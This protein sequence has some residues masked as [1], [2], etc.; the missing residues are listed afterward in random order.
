[1]SPTPTSFKSFARAF[2]TFCVHRVAASHVA[3]YHAA[4]RKHRPL[5]FLLAVC[6]CLSG[7]RK[8]ASSEPP[9]A[10]E[11]GIS[12]YF[13]PK[14]GCTAAIVEQL[15]AAMQTIDMQAYSFTSTDIVQA[16]VNAQA[17][18]VKVRAV[19][20]RKENA[21]GQYSGATYLLNHQVP[22]WT[23]GKHPIAHNKVMIIDG[24]TIVTGSFNFTQQAENLN[25]ENMLIITGKPKLAAAYETNFEEHLH[26]SDP[27]TGV[28]DK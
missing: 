10:V 5:L 26:H 25:A 12:V 6:L 23:D 16:L 28:G 22:T 11:D 20:D 24:A 17:R 1:M 21:T 13:S 2:L 14:G 27:Y 19:L 9:A 18:G 8:P 4:M 7:T 15:N 3:R